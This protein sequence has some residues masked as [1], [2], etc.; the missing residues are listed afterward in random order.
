MMRPSSQSIQALEGGLATLESQLMTVVFAALVFVDA[1]ISFRRREQLAR[2]WT[3]R[4]LPDAPIS[5]IFP[6]VTITIGRVTYSNP[7]ARRLERLAALLEKLPVV[8][9]TERKVLL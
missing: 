9:S 2:A 5:G 3:R 8:G 6:N 1:F 4:P 7:T